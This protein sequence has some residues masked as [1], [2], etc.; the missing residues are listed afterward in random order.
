MPPWCETGRGRSLDR[1]L[2]RLALLALG[3]LVVADAQ[4]LLLH[5]LDL[6]L[7]KRRNSCEQ[8]LYSRVEYL[9]SPHNL[10]LWAVEPDR[11]AVDVRTSTGSGGFSLGKP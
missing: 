7:L 9:G 5:P 4:H 2:H 10:G 3:L 1:G 8:P 11:Q 6:G